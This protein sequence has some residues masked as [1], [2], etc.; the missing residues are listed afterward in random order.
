MKEQ[1]LLNYYKK[2]K[3]V[4]CI[5]FDFKPLEDFPASPGYLI[6]ELIKRYKIPFKAVGYYHNIVAIQTKKQCMFWKDTGTGATFLGIVNLDNNQVTIKEDDIQPQ[7]DKPFNTFKELSAEIG[8]RDYNNI[9][10]L[11]ANITEDE[12]FYFLEVLPPKR[13]GNKWFILSEALNDNLFY[14]FMSYPKNNV[15]VCEVVKC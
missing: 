15:Y 13:M 5:D 10:G 1:T 4:D 9:L 7:T 8:K 2:V 11:K 14:K 12:Y 3:F 6:I